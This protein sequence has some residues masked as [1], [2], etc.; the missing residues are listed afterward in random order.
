MNNIISN[1]L[2]FTANFIKDVSVLKKDYDGEYRPYDISL[3]E[4]DVEDEND[5][6]SLY[7][8]ASLWSENGAY[9]AFGIFNDASKE[10]VTFDVEKEHYYA[11]T[12]QTDKFSHINPN[13]VLGLAMFSEMK[14]DRNRLDFLEVNPK[15]SKMKSKNRQ[16][17]EVGKAMVQYL[18]NNYDRRLELSADTKA[19]DFYKKLGFVSPDNK[20]PEV[21]Y[22]NA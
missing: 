2:N 20:H 8:T 7:K 3:V 16:Y 17:K 19:I 15:T 4:F 21:M 18:I 22:I 11:L 6:R 5:I 9:Y 10:Y 12:T 1:K 13:K 14:Y